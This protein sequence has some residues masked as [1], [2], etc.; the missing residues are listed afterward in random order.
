VAAKKTTERKLDIFT[1][2]GKISTKDTRYYRSLNDEEKKGFLPVVVSRW[3]SG[4]SSAKQIYFINE[5]VNPFVFSL[6]KHPQLLYQLM[7]LCGPGKSQRYFWNK[8]VSS[9]SNKT[10][11][12]VSVLREVFGY[13]TK[14]ALEA[15]PLLSNDDII[16]YAEHLGRQ[17]DVIT[18][19]KK[20]LK[21][22]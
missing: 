4:T 10:P 11:T 2:L 8:T 5:L 16:E 21:T 15:M 7:T 14:Q 3:L 12:A 1:V 18:K 20:E 22:R 13:N 9:K 6:H 19:L 17:K